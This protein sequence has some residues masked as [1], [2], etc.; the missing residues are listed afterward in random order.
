MSNISIN[1]TTFTS[2][3][4]SLNQAS[5]GLMGNMIP[6]ILF[7]VSMAWFSSMEYRPRDS[8]IFASFASLTAAALLRMIDLVSDT[9]LIL[10]IVLG[11]AAII[12]IIVNFKD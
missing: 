1:G 12:V 8:F 5:E 4:Q 7:I 9:V 2:F 6:F 3:L 10:F 11:V